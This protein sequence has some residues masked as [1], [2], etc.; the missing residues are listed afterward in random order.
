[1]TRD[2]TAQAARKFFEGNFNCAES[3]LLA[4]CAAWGITSD[5]IPRIATPFG[6][7]LGRTNHVCGT[8]TGGAMAIGL[9]LGRRRQEEK[10]DPA[11]LMTQRLVALF[12]EEHGDTACTVLLGVDL[13]TP[14]G[15]KA[16]KDLKLR[17]KCAGFV[18]WVAGELYDLLPV[19]KDAPS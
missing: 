8:L 3:V 4:M 14:E 19:E 17:D 13:S 11:Y 6:G 9:R 10:S 5:L 18:E 2:E 16:F 1:M 15:H 7:G 12:R